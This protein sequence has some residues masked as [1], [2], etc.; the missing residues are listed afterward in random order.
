MSGASVA[1][2]GRILTPKSQD[3]DDST[4][5]LGPQNQHPEDVL[6]LSK[7]IYVIFTE[8]LLIFVDPAVIV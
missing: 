7:N 5:Y 4:S 3:V 6:G 2:T 8:R 1:A